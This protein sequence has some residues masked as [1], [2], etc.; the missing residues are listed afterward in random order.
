MLV[1]VVVVVGPPI[2]CPFVTDVTVLSV[3]QLLLVGGKIFNSAPPGNRHNSLPVI[4]VT[5]VVAELPLVNILPFANVR[6]VLTTLP[7]PPPATK[8]FVK[9]TF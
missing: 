6:L 9:I 5:V 3:L 8:L 7:Q 1:A 4:V 2:L